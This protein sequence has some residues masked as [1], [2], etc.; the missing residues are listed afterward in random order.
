MK[1][2]ILGGGAVGITYAALLVN[3]GFEAMVYSESSSAH[4]GNTIVEGAVEFHGSIPYTR[5]IE[6]AVKHADV[7]L[8]ARCAGGVQSLIEEILPYIAPHQTLIFS[9]EL[10]LSSS[11]ADMRLQSLGKRVPIISWSTTVATAQRLSAN[12]VISGTLRSRIDYS[13]TS[14]HPA[15][16]SKA[17]LESLFGPRFHPLPNALAVALSNLN[18][19]I[20]LANSLANLTRI[21]K[22][23]RW[24]N[25]AGITP[26]VG[27]V[28]EALDGE[29]MALAERFGFQVR[30]VF[31]HYLQTFPGLAPG[32][33][34][35]M[36]A[37][38]SEKGPT[39]L[40]P[41][42]IDTRYLTEDIPYGLVPLV[43]LGEQA[44]VAMPLHN[45]GIRLACAYTGRDFFSENT[46]LPAI[47]GYWQK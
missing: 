38:V 19:A 27:R 41:R 28:I 21:E 1:V 46:M 12:H 6:T 3:N 20:H 26:A 45:A 23:E 15:N 36:A 11:Y 47:E 2:S 9:A 7:L 22:G 33:V 32:S 16:D 39:A 17:L 42:S 35:E 37:R 43:C 40:G 30:D 13:V 44:G 5:S 31:E 25:Y 8:C 34:S 18:P 10:S 14:P 24:D 29:R 4:A